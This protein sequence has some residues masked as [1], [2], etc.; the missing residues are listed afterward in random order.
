MIPFLVD[1][2]GD[3]L[4]YEHQARDLA[5]IERVASHEVMTTYNRPQNVVNLQ[6]LHDRVY[7]LMG[8]K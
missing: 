3:R 4:Y 2:W 6:A 7:F 1:W 5:H 8:V